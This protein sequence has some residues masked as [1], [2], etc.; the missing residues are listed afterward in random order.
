VP[1]AA[2]LLLLNLASV[3]EPVAGFLGGDVAS[4]SRNLVNFVVALLIEGAHMYVTHYR[5]S[6]N[7][8]FASQYRRYVVSPLIVPVVVIALAW[9]KRV[10]FAFHY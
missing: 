4:T 6:L 2:Y 10:P 9:L 8:D 1:Y 7:R 3:L 5:I